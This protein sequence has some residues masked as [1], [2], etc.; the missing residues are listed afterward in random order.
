MAP[1]ARRGLATWLADSSTPIFLLDDRRTVLVFN[2]GCEEL[3]QWP[4]AEV[5]GKTCVT[6]TS[7]APDQVETLTGALSPPESVYQ[8]KVACVPLICPRRDGSLIEKYVHFLPLPDGNDAAIVRVMG[9]IVEIPLV[10]SPAGSPRRDAARHLAILHRRYR[11]DRLTAVSPAMRQT[12]A[13]IAIARECGASVHLRGERG[14]GKEHIAR[15]IHYSGPRRDERFIPIS[16]ATATHFE[17]HRTLQRLAEGTGRSSEPIGV[18]YLDQVERL[19][20]DQQ[21]RVLQL[22]ELAGVRWMSS[23]SIELTELSERDFSPELAS[24]LTSIVI[25][26]PPLRERLEDLPGLAQQMI[27]ET[28][29][30]LQPQRDGLSLEVER[31]FLTYDW[32][33]NLDE[34]S[35]V[36]REACRRRPAGAIQ[37]EDL[38]WE[39]HAGREA[40][41]MRP[42]RPPIPLD[43]RLET[44]ERE[45]IERALQLTRGNRAAAAELL[46]IP[47][48]RLYRRMETLGLIDSTSI[49]IDTPPPEPE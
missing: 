17:V 13:R 34:L 27:E 29:V 16:C 26:V 20:R 1:R 4:M 38:P 30:P 25:A 41:E 12:A 8:G 9:V 22:Q 19:A 5:I 43:S 6:R 28:N 2:R 11:I 47:R 15:M 24:Q 23:S 31:A 39:F 18:V 45:Q 40:R 49:P 3:T 32:P 48:P 46:G 33:G 42:A 21:E 36:I 37:Y 14:T 44:F 35:S 7:G 10:S